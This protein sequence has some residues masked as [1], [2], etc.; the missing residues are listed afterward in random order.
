MALWTQ[1]TSEL[2]RAQGEH[3]ALVRKLTDND[4]AHDRRVVAVR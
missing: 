1:A 4:G 2:R 3:D